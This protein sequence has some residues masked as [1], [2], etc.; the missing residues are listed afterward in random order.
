MEMEK[1]EIEGCFVITSKVFADERG[2]FFESF[3]NEKFKKATGLDISFVQDNISVSRKNV[4]RGLHFQEGAH[5]QA[6][7][8]QAI[9]GKVLDVVVDIR[10]ES[11]TFGK[12]LKIILSEENR[13]Q[14]FVP[15]GIAHGFVVL[16]EEAVFSYKCDAYYHPASEAG[17]FYADEQLKIDWQIDMKEAIVSPKD[18]E[19]PTL[20]SY[21]D[22][23]GI[24]DRG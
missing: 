4:I 21:Y 15:K 3:H 18:Q 14:I 23:I 12:H 11:P 1:T 8:V 6:K 7:L 5:A 10:K 22:A 2:Q 16:S 9:K 13:K 17:I 19:L 24:G 20:K